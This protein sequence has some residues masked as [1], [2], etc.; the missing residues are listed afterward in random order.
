MNK[1]DQQIL[2]IKSEILFEK[3]KWDGLK[4]EDLN[5]Y[6]QL[7]LEKSEFKRRG[8]LEENPDYKQIIPQ[9]I[10]KFENKYFLHQQVAGTEERLQ[11]MYPLPL[12]GHVEQFDL[13][14]EKDL[15]QTALEREVEEEVLIESKIV[16]REFIG[17]VYLEDDN[18][19]NHVHVGLFYIFELDGDDVEMNEEELEKVGFVDKKYLMD[20]MENLTYWSRVVLNE[21]DKI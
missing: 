18:P 11:K 1:L 2:C 5:Y 9:V 21:S 16:N 13:E 4:T 10:L 20:N 12:G 14:G 17:I 15:L 3:G 7:L 6:Y 19:V 8:D